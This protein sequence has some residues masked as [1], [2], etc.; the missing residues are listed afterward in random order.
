MFGGHGKRGRYVAAQPFCFDGIERIPRDFNPWRRRRLAGA[1]Y[2]TP[3]GQGCFGRSNW[4]HWARSQHD[5]RSSARVC[6]GKVQGHR[7]G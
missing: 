2:F 6:R 4:G 1:R 5:D 3:E 7:L